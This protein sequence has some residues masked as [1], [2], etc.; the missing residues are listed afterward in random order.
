[1]TK[2]RVEEEV[3]VVT[4]PTEK[5]SSWNS[6]NDDWWSLLTP[7]VPYVFKVLTGF[8]VWLLLSGMEDS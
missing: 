3:V 5:T 4:L 8:D 1:V 2:Y 7:F 6:S